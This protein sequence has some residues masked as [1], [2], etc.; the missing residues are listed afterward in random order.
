MKPSNF[1]KIKGAGEVKAHG[2]GNGKTGLKVVS[3]PSGGKFQGGANS[4][5]PPGLK[6]YKEGS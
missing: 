3:K 4:Y 1:G 6:V 2:P 5:N